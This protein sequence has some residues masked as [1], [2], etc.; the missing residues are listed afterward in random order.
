MVFWR[1]EIFFISFWQ[2]LLN[3]IHYNLELNIGWNRH[4]IFFFYACKHTQ[5]L[6]FWEWAD[7]WVTLWFCRSMYI[8]LTCITSNVDLPIFKLLCSVHTQNLLHQVGSSGSK[9]GQVKPSGSK[10]G[11]ITKWVQFWIQ[12]INLTNNPNIYPY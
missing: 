12:A 4:I 2:G 5:Q 1:M 9:M 10:I 6:I 8:V 7:T 3:R 11:L